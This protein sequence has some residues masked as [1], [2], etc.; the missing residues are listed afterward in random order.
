[1]VNRAVLHRFIEL[2]G[3]DDI[4]ER[5]ALIRRCDELRAQLEEQENVEAFTHKRVARTLWK[6]DQQH[7]RT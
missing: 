6:V 7:T 2:L 3:L 5:L 1:M 4:K